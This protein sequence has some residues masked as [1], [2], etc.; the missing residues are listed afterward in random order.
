LTATWVVASRQQ[1]AL[2]FDQGSLTITMDPAAYQDPKREYQAFVAE[3]NAQSCVGQVEGLPALVISPDTDCGQSNPAWV[4]FDLNRID[5]NVYSAGY[6][7]DQL[8][9]VADSM[10]QPT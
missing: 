9:D 7:D 8:L 10:A 6:S 4:E 3:D 1:A 5:I 2:V